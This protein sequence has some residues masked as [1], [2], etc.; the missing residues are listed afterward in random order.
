ME[1]YPTYMKQGSSERGIYH[2]KIRYLG[3]TLVSRRQTNG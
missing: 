1:K 3:T 2:V